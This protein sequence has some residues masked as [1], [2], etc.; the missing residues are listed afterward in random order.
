MLR[1][2]TD[3]FRQLQEDNPALYVSLRNQFI[4]AME[5]TYTFDNTNTGQTLRR[6]PRRHTFWWQ[7]TATSAGNVTSAVYRIF[8]QPFGKREKRLMG[9]PFAQFLKLNT[10]LR[11]HY[12]IDR[13]QSLASRLA[14]GAIWSYG[15]ATTA[16]YTEQFYIGGANSVRAFSARSIGPGGYP[17]N[18]DNS[19]AFINHVG[20]IRFEANVEYRFRIVSDLHGAVFLDAGNVWLMRRDEGRPG[21]RV[22]AKGLSPPDSPGHRGGHPLRHGLPGV[23]PG[24][25]HRP[26]RPLRHRAARLLQHPPLQGRHGHTLR[27]RLIRSKAVF[28]CG[29]MPGI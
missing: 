20:D 29:F 12:R 4:P 9:V 27:H 11:H 7:T 2:P 13:N 10:E 28:P 26:A 14:L 16:P 17:P 21:G 15:N 6:R 25:G 1:N 19:Y 5:Y 18:E 23:P 22:H 8:G 3:E 24:L